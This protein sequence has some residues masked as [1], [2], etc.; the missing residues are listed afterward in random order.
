MVNRLDLEQPITQRSLSQQMVEELGRQ[1]NE[2][3]NRI[4]TQVAMDQC[5]NVTDY[6]I[7]NFMLSC[8]H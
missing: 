2:K 7:P 5:P 1:D 3:S 4:K 8:Q 6:V